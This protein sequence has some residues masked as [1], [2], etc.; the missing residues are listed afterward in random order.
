MN[1]A[2]TDDQ[3]NRRDEATHVFKIGQSVRL[4]GAVGRSA[5]IA[6]VFRITAVLPPIGD[7]LQYRIRND[8]ERHERVATQENLEPLAKPPTAGSEKLTEKTFG[9]ERRAGK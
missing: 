4:I 5:Q 1:P 9:D 6:G 3:T 8:D 2:K 7:S